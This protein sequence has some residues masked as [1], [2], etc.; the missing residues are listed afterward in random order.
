MG[1]MP[2]IWLL[3]NK[4]K[5]DFD[6]LQRLA[7]EVGYPYEIKRLRFRGPN[8]PPLARLL[9]DPKSDSL[10]PPWPSIVMCAEAL[11]SVVA[12]GLRRI[13]QGAVKTV[14]IGRPAGTPAAFDLV[15]TTPQF[16]VPPAANVLELP[17][18]LVLKPEKKAA[19]GFDARRPLIAA[20]VGGSSP[21]DLL[22]ANAARQFAAALQNYAD[23]HG[24]TLAV[25]T[26]PRTGKGRNG[27]GV[28]AVLRKAIKAPHRLHVFGEGE[29]VY[30]GLLDEADEIVVTSDSVSMVA[31][32]IAT[33]KPVQVYLLPQTNTL[34]RRFVDACYSH[35]VISRPFRFCPIGYAHDIGVFKSTVDRVGLFNQLVDEGGL[36]WFSGASPVL[37][38][39]MEDRAVQLAIARVR[40]LVPAGL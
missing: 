17:L 27:P 26:S 6:Q 38:P 20:A 40:A 35:G 3:W 37:V 9:M 19:Y 7:T 22:D 31:E 2:R 11:P 36:S 29:N 39:H 10:R 30:T 34:K 24:G 23:R 21:P 14:C 18:P 4:R 32:A 1:E 12:R 5:G 28:L 16:H 15:V 25:V 8:F 33:G 13:S